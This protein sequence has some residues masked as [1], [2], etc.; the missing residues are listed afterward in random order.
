MRTFIAIAIPAT[1]HALIHSQQQ[2]LAG[3]LRTA[4]QGHPISWTPPDKVHITL[5][6][7]GDTAQSQRQTLQRALTTISAAHQPFAL[8]LEQIG[9]FPAW[10]KPSVL[11]LGIRDEENALLPLQQ[12]IEQAAQA[13]GFVAEPKSF[14]PHVTIGRLHRSIA[15]PQR[16]AIGQILAQQLATDASPPYPSAH[17]QVEQLVHMQSELQATGTRYTPLRIFRLGQPEQ[18]PGKEVG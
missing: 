1:C 11:W 6:F 18:A 3:L 9:C 2:R 13:A 10:Q 14:T 15:R 5:R 16:Q 12:Q 7:L 17:F 4:Q 8:F